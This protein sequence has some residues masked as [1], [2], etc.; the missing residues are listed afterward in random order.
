MLVGARNSGLDAVGVDEF[1]A[2]FEATTHLIAL[3][4]TRIGA[5]SP[6]KKNRLKTDGFI[7]AHRIH[8][9]PID[10]GQ[11][12][13]PVE[14]STMA[15]FRAMRT[16]ADRNLGIT[17][18]FAASDIYALGVM[19]WASVNGVAVPQDLS[20]VGY[21]NIDMAEFAHTSLTSVRN[22]GPTLAKAA[23]DR[24][25]TLMQS[26]LPLPPPT[27]TFMPGDLEIRESSSRPGMRAWTSDN[28]PNT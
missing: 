22:D 5:L 9:L 1:Q 3:G 20:I 4:H 7:H 15:G 26:D 28:R 12:V 21:D 18:V 10:E 19:R 6:I 27:L 14:L 17:A 13:D 23:V 8:G 24:L 11:I 2:A 16:L 25:I